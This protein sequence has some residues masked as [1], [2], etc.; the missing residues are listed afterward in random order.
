MQ[1]RTYD[2]KIKIIEAENAY[3]RREII[4]SRKK[5]KEASE[6][7][8]KLA[9]TNFYMENCLREANYQV[10]NLKDENKFLMKYRQLPCRRFEE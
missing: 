1:R 4:S 2:S 5:R 8:E 6:N 10:N 3:L 9:E 7:A